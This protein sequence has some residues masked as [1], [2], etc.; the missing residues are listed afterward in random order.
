MTAI[1]FILGVLAGVS[2][3][4][5]MHKFLLVLEVRRTSRE[6]RRSI[7]PEDWRRSQMTDDDA[8]LVRIGERMLLSLSQRD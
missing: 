4:V 6:W 3:T 7:D 1:T 8:E 2:A 5:V